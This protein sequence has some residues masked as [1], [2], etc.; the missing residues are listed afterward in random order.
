VS[1]IFEREGQ[2]ALSAEVNRFVERMLPPRTEKEEIAKQL[3]EHVRARHI[4]A[5]HLTR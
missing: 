5:Q 4:D 3:R 1:E 2:P